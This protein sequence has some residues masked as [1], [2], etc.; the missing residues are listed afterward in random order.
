MVLRQAI[1][2]SVASRGSVSLEGVEIII[3]IVVT[4]INGPQ[5]N[6]YVL[7]T[8]NV[9]R[10]TTTSLE[11]LYST[12]VSRYNSVRRVC[13]REQASESKQNYSFDDIELF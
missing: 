10:G 11:I 4:I 8:R 2:V 3:I 6:V 13:K 1:C 9:K 12:P 5:P 7:R